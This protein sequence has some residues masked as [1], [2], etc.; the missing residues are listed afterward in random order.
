MPALGERR[1]AAL[2]IL[3]V[4]VAA[5]DDRCRRAPA[6]GASVLD[7]R[8]RSPRRPAPSAR[9]RAAAASA[10]DQRGERSG[11][12]DRR[13]RR[14][15][16]SA[17]PGVADRSR[18]RAR[19]ARASRRAMLPPMRPRPH[20]ADREGRHRC[21]R[22]ARAARI[23]PARRAR[24][25]PPR[26]PAART[27]RACP[28]VGPLAEQ[29]RRERDAVDRL[30]RGDD[31]RRVRRHAS[32]ATRRTACARARCRRR[33]ARRC[34][35]MSRSRRRDDRARARATNGTR[36]AAANAFC[37]SAIARA[38]CA[39][40]EA[41]VAH[42]EQRERGT[43]QH[44]P[45]RVPAR[46]RRR[47]R[48]AGTSQD[49]ARRRPAARRAA[50][51]RLARRSP[52]DALDQ[53][54]EQ[55]EARVAEQADRDAGRWIAA[56][57]VTQWIASTTPLSAS[58]AVG[59]ASACVKRRDERERRPRR[60]PCARARSR[61]ATAPATCRTA[62]RSR[63][64]RRRRAATGARERVAWRH[65]RTARF[66]AARCATT[67][68]HDSWVRLQPD[69][70][71]RHPHLARRLPM[72]AARSDKAIVAD[73]LKSPTPGVKVAVADIDGIL[74]GKSLH[75]DKF[76]S[77]VEGGFGFCDVVYGWDMHDQC[78]D[79]TTTDRLAQGL[80]RTRSRAST[81]R[82]TATCRG[83][84]A[85]TSSSATSSRIENGQGSAL[86]A[87]RPPGAEARARA[88]ARSS[89]SSRCARSSSSSSTSPRRR[90]AGPRRRAS[91]PSRS[92]RA[93]SAT[94]CCAPSHAR[95]YFNA[96]FN[97][98]AAFG[99]PIEGLHT[100]T[101]PGVYEAAIVYSDA[102][103]AARPRAAVQDRREGDR[104]ALRHHAELHGEVEPAL[105]GLLRAH[106]PEPVRRQEERV[107]RREPR[108]APA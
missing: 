2:R 59:R 78:Y 86:P 56:K 90:R 9:R 84:A 37:H 94:R 106:P 54:H 40:G 32:R 18:R 102:L 87:R 10:C 108:A 82:R 69:A 73:V 60:R 100:E 35:A 4:G 107:P 93:C 72:P 30:E 81:S 33:P 62:R 1:R 79:N 42:G 48:S 14:A 41:A 70:F 98:M 67:A 45:A 99:V 92:R 16:A 64:A 34:S 26:R 105:P 58:P 11:R 13:L 46:P 17:A 52:R 22:R 88:R 8:A 24:R 44:A 55:R 103:E 91:A 104:R 15:S 27:R 7:R 61:P 25:R 47:R 49:A 80:S 96:L 68:S 20:D 53:Q 19:R 36:H 21:D 6:S 57:N 83:T 5:V 43:R 71:R 101:G 89:A 31:A 12:L 50:S 28:R 39:R 74:R 76:V 38:A 97:E 75:K 65:R 3:V 95:D 23:L 51:R 85:S 66:S 29:H 63:T 77:A